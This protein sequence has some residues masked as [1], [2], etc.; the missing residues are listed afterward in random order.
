MTNGAGST[1]V[2]GA[3]YDYRLADVSYTGV[4]EYHGLTT[5][6]VEAFEP[7]PDRFILYQNYPNPFNAQTVISYYLP[8]E[9]YV[10]LSIYDL[11]GRKLETLESGRLV[12]GRHKVKWDA[13]NVA[14]GVYIYRISTGSFGETEQGI[15]VKKLVVLK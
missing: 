7:L 15:A 14:S 1:V 5:L 10:T 13:S 2:A 4:V 11:T 9:S 12:S 8:N 6:L 3:T